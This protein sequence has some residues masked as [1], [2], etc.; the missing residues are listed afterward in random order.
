MHRM[1]TEAK[2][3]SL[4]SSEQNRRGRPVFPTAAATDFLKIVVALQM[5]K[6]WENGSNV[7]G[8]EG[9]GEG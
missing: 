1:A 4:L 7:G 6:D 2:H 5:E 3:S 9:R 8:E